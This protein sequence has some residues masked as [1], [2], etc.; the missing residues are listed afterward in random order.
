MQT[1][2]SRGFTTAELL[3]VIAIAL[4]LFLP[5]S[6]AVSNAKYNARTA[7][8][9]ANFNQMRL[10][11]QS[12]Q[13]AHGGKL[14]PTLKA[15]L[16]ITHS[17]SVFLC[18]NA[19]SSGPPNYAAIGYDYR[20]L[21]QPKGTDVICWDTQPHRPMHS[22]FAWLNR[23]NRNVLLADGQVKNMPEAQFQ[24]LHLVGQTWIIR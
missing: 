3:V 16:P 4:V 2:T 15:L 18:P 23:P 6:D 14:P 1:R 5:F 17:R 19:G 9:K 20:F 22:V 8:C 10:A 24:R 7:S 13:D 21:A 11:A 12:Y